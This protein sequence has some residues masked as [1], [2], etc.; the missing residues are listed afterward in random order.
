M[1]WGCGHNASKVLDAWH[2]GCKSVTG[3]GNSFLN[4]NNVRCFFEINRREHR[5]GAVTG[6]IWRH[7]SD[8]ETCTKVGSFRIEG[9]GEITRAPSALKRFAKETLKEIKADRRDRQPS[10]L[11]VYGTSGFLS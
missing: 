8:G 4:D 6:S 1:G 3:S 11:Q 7:N 10:V 5:D 9:T 2:E